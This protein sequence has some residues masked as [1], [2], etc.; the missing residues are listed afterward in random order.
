V[1]FGICLA[2]NPFLSSFDLVKRP[3]YG[4]SRVNVNGGDFR[5]LPA[6]SSAKAPSW[7]PDGIAYQSNTSLEIT[8]DTSDGKTRMLLSAPY[9]QD[10]DWQPSGNRIVFQS[11]EGSHWEIFGVNEDGTGLVALT[12][13]VTTLVDELPS[14][15]SPAWSPDGKQIVYL[16]NR[17]DKNAAGAWRLWVMNADGSD[18]RPL[19]IDLTLEYTYSAEQSVDWGKIPAN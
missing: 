13:P 15:V 1:G 18:Q 12:R 8:S 5:D 14:N 2:D 16:S 10:P 9:Y 4:L 3:D 11:R 17:D 6:L 19:P 7:S